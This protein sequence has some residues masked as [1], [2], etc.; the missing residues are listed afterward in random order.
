VAQR[1]RFLDVGYTSTIIS[2]L[3]HCPTN[4]ANIGTSIL[5]PNSLFFIFCYT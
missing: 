1:P 4:T 5:S 3:G 2:H